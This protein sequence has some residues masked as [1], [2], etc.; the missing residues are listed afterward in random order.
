MQIRKFF[1]NYLK[2]V[3]VLLTLSCL[4]LTGC[5][6]SQQA[7]Q[8]APPVPEV[9]TM[10]VETQKIT[11]TT[12]LPGRTSALRVAEIR[13]Q[14]NGIIQK[15]LFTEG[16]EV[17]AGEVLYEID[18]APFQAA[19]DNALANLEVSRE[20]AKRARAALDA[21]IAGVARQ[22]AVLEL[23]R[24][25]RRRME[26]LLIDKAVSVSQRDQAVTEVQV[27]E[28]TMRSA[29]AQVESDRKNI[30]A[31]DAVI[32]Q[33]EAAVKTAHINM[34]Y[35]RITAPISGRIGKS[36]ITEGGLVT[37]Y[38]PVALATIQQL[39]PIYVDV[40]Q[41]TT[42][43]LRLKQR[44]TSG[45]L[46]QSGAAQNQVSLIL[47]DGTAYSEKGTLQ[48]QDVTVDPTTGSVTLRIVFPNPE[49][50]LLPGMFVRATVKEG[51]NEQAILIPQQAVSRDYKGNPAALIVTADSKVE[52]A[53]LIL[54]R[55]LEDKWLV[56]S[57]LKPGDRV[58]VEGLQKVRPGA[59]VRIAQPP[60]SS[61]PQAGGKEGG[62]PAEKQQNPDKT[63]ATSK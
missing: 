63:P 47:E 31:S 21:G 33:A 57:G 26:E 60:L 48:F 22:K 1:F 19:L 9:V 17:K 32:Q 50:V 39:D 56:T 7:P 25:S 45:S 12:E 51:I 44:L 34:G 28:A 62:Q 8:Q 3:A 37:A 59:T 52:Q 55:S 16:A 6:K 41:S 53:P 38:Q 10:T 15:R 13:P 40:P 36:N 58:I 20:S 24:T 43:L 35:T 23:S 30:A 14:V 61:P 18:P 27:A 29:E 46:N 42:E 11:L 54:D 4:L 2:T 5:E 49:D